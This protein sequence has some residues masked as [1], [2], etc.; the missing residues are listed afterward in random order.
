MPYDWRDLR[1][2]EDKL[3]GLGCRFIGTLGLAKSFA[4][5]PAYWLDLYHDP[6]SKWGDGWFVA[7]QWSFQRDGTLVEG[8][9]VS[10]RFG[11][12]GQA[13]ES[14]KE[15]LQEKLD[16]QWKLHEIKQCAEHSSLSQ[17]EETAFKLIHGMASQMEPGQVQAKVGAPAEAPP[18]NRAERMKSLQ[19]KRQAKSEW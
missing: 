10:H 17:M 3:K 19:R 8:Q 5:R 9:T 12:P 7:R 16:K 11:T 14:M 18:Q 4:R 2:V 1:L 15:L 6:R 13:M